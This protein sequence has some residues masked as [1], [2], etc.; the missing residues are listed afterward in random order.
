MFSKLST[1][2]AR[3]PLRRVVQ[4]RLLNKA[5]IHFTAMRMEEKKEE[6]IAAPAPE[7]TPAPEPVA[8]MAESSFP[9]FGSRFYITAEVTVSKLFPAGFG[10]QYSSTIADGMGYQADQLEFFAITGGGDFVGVLGGHTAFYTIKNAVVGGGSMK[11]IVGDGLWLASAAF[12][13]GFAWQPIVNFWQGM[14]VPFVGVFAGTWAGCGLAFFGGLRLGRM[15]LPWMEGT[16]YD[17]L[18][19]DASLSAAIGGATAFFVGTDVAY[20]PTENFLIDQL[21]IQDSA[22]D[23]EGCVTAGTSTAVGFL[24]AQT[25]EN[26]IYPKNTCWLD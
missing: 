6:K 20:K 2:L 22:T 12:C 15:V 17:N 16:T 1:P 10:W 5:P 21:G 8:T 11:S 25:V 26:I 14:D 13:S 23:I 7:P 18:K 9:N 3:A 4:P 19:N 24:A